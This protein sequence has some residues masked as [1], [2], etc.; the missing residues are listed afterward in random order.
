MP[1]KTTGSLGSLILLRKADDERTPSTDPS[2]SCLV[3]ANP[4]LCIKT[5][6]NLAFIAFAWLE[7]EARIGERMIMLKWVEA[8]VTKVFACRRAKTKSAPC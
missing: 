2:S 6:L 4:R 7:K 3:T 1:E 8:I 5:P